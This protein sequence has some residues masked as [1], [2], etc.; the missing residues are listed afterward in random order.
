[1]TLTF[2]VI[3]SSIPATQLMRVN[4]A[5][6]RWS[7]QGGRKSRNTEVFGNERIKSLCRMRHGKGLDVNGTR[8]EYANLYTGRISSG[9]AILSTCNDTLQPLLPCKILPAGGSNRGGA[10]GDRGKERCL[11]LRQ[12]LQLFRQ[13]RTNNF[14][15][16]RSRQ[17]WAPQPLISSIQEPIHQRLA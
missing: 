11:I 4:D 14:I 5:K 12:P 17:G 10:K 1:M 3:D 9:R 13:R 2:S 15:A 7:P 8:P 6:S 16:R